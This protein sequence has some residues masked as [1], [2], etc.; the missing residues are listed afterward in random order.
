MF[1]EVVGNKDILDDP[2]VK[3]AKKEV[4]KPKNTIKHV[5]PIRVDKNPQ[6]TFVPVKT[7]TQF[8]KKASS[9]LFNYESKQKEEK[10]KLE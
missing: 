7:I 8:G 6:R 1:N 4:R 2:P 3:L 5:A 9:R 10:L